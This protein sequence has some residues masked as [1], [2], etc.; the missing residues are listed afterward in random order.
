M[1][2]DWIKMRSDI[3]R[4]PKVSV[5]AEA[6]LE[7]G[8]DLARFVNQMCQRDM[9]VTRNV[10]RNATVGALVSIWGVMRQRG[11]RFGDDLVCDGVT[12]H[13]LDDVADMP[14]FGD[15]MQRAG[16]V[17]A[18]ADGIAFRRF[19]SE[20]NVDP[21]EKTKTSNAERQ[22]RYRER[23]AEAEKLEKGD[24]N[25]DVTRDVTVTPREEKRREE[26]KTPKAPKGATS[27][28]GFETFWSA[29]PRK[30]A[31]PQAIKAFLRLGA[32]SALLAQMLGALA[33]QRQSE[34]WQRDGGQFIPHPSTWLNGRR[35]EDD[36]PAQVGKAVKP[37]AGAL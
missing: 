4:D 11:K 9:A 26:I 17:E 33:V 34:Q 32:D 3:Y 15:A 27:P 29:Y 7:Q 5:M 24:A 20:H 35:W 14:G 31:K 30:T 6:L 12:T 10:M 18:T 16:W 22:R 2:S 23:K 25:S 13:V 19:F 8:G 28:E 1:A 21:A 37:W 36:L